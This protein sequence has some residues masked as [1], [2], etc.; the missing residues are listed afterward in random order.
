[1]K[2]EAAA[3]SH[4]DA[5]VNVS[6]LFQPKW[7]RHYAASKLR[8]DP[9]FATAYELLR[10]SDEPLLD[11]GCGVGLL[12]LY[13]RARGWQQEVTALDL[14]ERKTKHA[15]AAAFAAGYAGLV[16]RE[17]DAAA[18]T[19]PEFRGN[20]A[21]F[22]A[23]HYL[24]ATAQQTLLAQ[25]AARIATGGMLLLRDCPRDGSPRFWA[26]YIAEKFAQAISWNVAV[27]LEFPTRHSINAA[28]AENHF[29][30]AERPMHSGGPFN[31][32]LFIIRRER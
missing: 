28:F 17:H 12:P 24:R 15:K 2:S 29:T 9:V 4:E 27:P 10:D 21:L 3:R 26:T 8:R 20:I 11:V 6:G 13:L 16:F 23:L 7:L 18:G 25:L 14:D 5:C 1:M 30:R 22:D 19:L 32:S 31:N